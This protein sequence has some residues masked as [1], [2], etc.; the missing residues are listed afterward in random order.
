MKSLAL[1]AALAI[2]LA[3]PG[4]SRFIEYDGPEVTRVE[5]FKSSRT[6]VL[7]HHD[8]VL[9]AFEIELGFAPEGHKAQEGDGRTP[10]GDYIVDR[11]NP[12]SEYYLSIGINYPD[13]DDIAAAEEAGVDPGGD[14]FIHGTP[15]A[16]RATDDWTAG[17]IAVSD[18][19]MRRIY[20][21]VQDGTPIGI[22][23]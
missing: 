5:V 7:W 6:M 22:F 21:M 4:C 10:E 11:R 23:P 2:L 19:E 9:E 18:R 3:G 1:V 14:I 13:A 15:R 8:E 20:A 17:C 16:F 12:N